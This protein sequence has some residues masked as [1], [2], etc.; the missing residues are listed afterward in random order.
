MPRKATNNG[1]FFFKACLYLTGMDTC[2]S[3]ET[4]FV[5]GE[6]KLAVCINTVQPQKSE[7]AGASG[8]FGAIHTSLAS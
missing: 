7:D 8:S 4:T 3:I 5:G 1:S 2:L 6:K